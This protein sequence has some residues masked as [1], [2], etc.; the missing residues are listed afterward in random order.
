MG[1]IYVEIILVRIFFIKPTDDILLGDIDGYGKADKTTPLQKVLLGFSN[2]MVPNAPE[3][4]IKAFFCDHK[5]N[6]LFTERI[7]DD[8]FFTPEEFCQADH[9]VVGEFD[10]YGQFSGTVA[11]Y[12]KDPKPYIK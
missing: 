6:N 12:G 9:Q 2:T 4:P 1:L 8:R 10:E 11:I 5:L 3:P 7:A